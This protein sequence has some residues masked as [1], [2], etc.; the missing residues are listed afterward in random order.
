MLG[1]LKTLKEVVPIKTNSTLQN[2]IRLNRSLRNKKLRKQQR[3][4]RRINRQH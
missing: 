4:S 2:N 1:F 3:L